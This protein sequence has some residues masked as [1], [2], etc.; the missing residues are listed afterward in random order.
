MQKDQ[1]IHFTLGWNFSVFSPRWKVLVSQKKF[2][3]R[4]ISPRL[5]VTCLRKHT[6]IRCSHPEVFQGK[7]VLKICSKFTGEHP[8][9]SAISIKLLQHGCSPLNFLHVFRTAFLKNTSAPL[10]LAYIRLNLTCFVHTSNKRFFSTELHYCLYELS[11]LS[12][13][14]VINHIMLLKQTYLIFVHF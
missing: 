11:L 3:P 5:R 7:H 10:F 14:V 4:W 13:F 6:C 1:N 2:T 12:I 8:Y 9:R